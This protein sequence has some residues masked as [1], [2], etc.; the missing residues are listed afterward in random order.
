MMTRKQ[1]IGHDIGS[2]L[3]KLVEPKEIFVGSNSGNLYGLEERR[4]AAITACAN[5]W[6]K[7]NN[8][9]PDAFWTQSIP[10]TLFDTLESYSPQ[11][12][13]IAAE[14]FL[15]QFG[16]EIGRPGIGNGWHSLK[17]DPPG[18]E[19]VTF[20]IG[21]S[22]GGRTELVFRW[23]HPETGKAAFWKSGKDGNFVLE[24][25]GADVWHAGPP[26]IPGSV[27]GNIQQDRELHAAKALLEQHGWKVERPSE[28]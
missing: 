4:N 28:A 12:S 25:K 5:A 16:W 7:V 6:A 11:Y 8:V 15:K 9:D 19:H 26:P 24:W 20:F 13:I 23:P 2:D 3:A 18:E 14:A 10:Q 27:V 21:H 17:D 22:E 1:Q